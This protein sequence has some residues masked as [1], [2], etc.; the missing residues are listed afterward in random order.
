M[1]SPL[2]FIVVKSFSEKEGGIRKADHYIIGIL[3][4]A[5][6]YTERSLYQVMSDSEAAYRR[7][8]ESPAKVRPEKVRK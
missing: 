2:S 4:K 3:G 6:D 8:D 1:N 5:D 7:R